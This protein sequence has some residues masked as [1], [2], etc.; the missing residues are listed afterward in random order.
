MNETLNLSVLF[1]IGFGGLG[2]IFFII[3]LV[4]LNKFKSKRIKCTEKTYGKVTDIIK[5]ISLNTDGRGY[6]YMWY[7]VFEYTI[8]ELKFKKQSY[9]GGGQ[10]K[11]A[12]GQEVEI[13]YNPENYNEFYVSGE[14][15]PKTIGKIFSIIGIVL[16]ILAVFSLILTVS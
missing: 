11:F 10:V 16:M 9:Y 8:G 4:L 1:L 14:N 5:E 7:P 13:Y 6:T 2:G 15:T 3:G 12:I